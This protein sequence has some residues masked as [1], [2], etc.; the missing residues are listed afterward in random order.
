MLSLLT[1]MSFQ[2]HMT[3][4]LFCSSHNIIWT[5]F[6]ILYVFASFLNALLYWG[7]ILS[8]FV[9][10][11]RNDIKA[12]HLQFG[13]NYSLFQTCSFQNISDQQQS[14]YTF[15]KEISST[16]SISDPKCCWNIIE[17]NVHKT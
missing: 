2:F 5:T 4:L 13:V 14:N 3:G 11:G 16:L 15:S 8:P 1:I 6:I 9:L 12:K 7:K 10:H 17:A